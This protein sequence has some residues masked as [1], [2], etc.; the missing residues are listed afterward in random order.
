MAET[1]EEETHIPNDVDCE[2]SSEDDDEAADPKIEIELEKGLTGLGF[3][4]RG[5]TDNQY[6]LGD[7]G[8]FVTTIKSDGAAAK[9]GR[10]ER[11]DKIL[12]INGVDVTNVKHFEAVQ[13]FHKSKDR[14]SLVVQKGLDKKDDEDEPLPY[15]PDSS[16]YGPKLA[17]FA[18][19]AVG[20][21]LIYFFYSKRQS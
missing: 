13:L 5:G 4:I 2:E 10:L 16:K 17:Y 7:P 21:G 11:G 20:I 18:I 12:E 8:I 3:N 15:P 1:P 9:D 6:L 14:V 19:A